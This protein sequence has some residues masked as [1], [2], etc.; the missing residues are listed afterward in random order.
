MNQQPDQLKRPEDVQTVLDAARCGATE[1]PPELKR[2]LDANPVI[3]QELP[4]VESI[5][6]AAW[7]DRIAKTNLLLRDSLSRKLDALREE[8]AGP[9]PSPLESMAVERVLA[10]W[11]QVEFAD[12]YASFVEPSEDPKLMGLAIKMQDSAQRRYDSAVKNLSAVQK[13]RLESSKPPREEQR[14]IR[15]PDTVSHRAP[16][17][18]KACG[19]VVGDRSRFAE[20]CGEHESRFGVGLTG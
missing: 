18:G 7:L 9:S 2:I 15:K 16:Q 5:V 20:N 8:M 14:P 10:T 19:D 12:L 4:R 3:W 11:L 13:F 6:E 1:A 17:N